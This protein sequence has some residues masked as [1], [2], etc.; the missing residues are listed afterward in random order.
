MNRTKC[1][2]EMWRAAQITSHTANT[3]SYG[4]SGHSQGLGLSLAAHGPPVGHSGDRAPGAKVL[5]FSLPSRQPSPRGRGSLPQAKTLSSPLVTP[6]PGLLR[7]PHHPLF[8]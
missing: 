8:S 1:S 6:A 2:E 3:S 7:P 4:S 5:G